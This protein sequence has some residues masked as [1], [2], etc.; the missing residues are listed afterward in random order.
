MG[1]ELMKWGPGDIVEKR[2]LPGVLWRI[3]SGRQISRIS[4]WGSEATFYE[5]EK[6]VDLR[7]AGATTPLTLPDATSVYEHN[8]CD[9]ANAMEAI[10]AAA[11]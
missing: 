6:V 7:P 9:P 8:L 3:L 10:A 4:R 5:I 2:M 1:A 11:L